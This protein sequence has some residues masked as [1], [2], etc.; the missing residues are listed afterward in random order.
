MHAHVISVQPVM[1]SVVATRIVQATRSQLGG[2]QVGAE[3]VRL[4]YRNYAPIL[5]AKVFQPL[6]TLDVYSSVIEAVLA[7]SMK[8]LA[9]LIL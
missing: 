4:K 1:Y 5:E 8:H 9:L 6:K 3:I 7:R 2:I